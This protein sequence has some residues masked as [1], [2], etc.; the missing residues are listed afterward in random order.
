MFQNGFLSSGGISLSLF[1]IACGV[2]AIL[3]MRQSGTQAI[4]EQQA[5][6]VLM[7][8]ITLILFGL[9]GMVLT[10]IFSL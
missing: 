5:R 10:A 6:E 4:S 1:M 2:F 3:W 8:G 9:F 7:I